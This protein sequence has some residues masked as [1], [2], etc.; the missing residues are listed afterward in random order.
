[1]SGLNW[2]GGML[3]KIWFWFLVLLTLNQ[4]AL[5][6]GLYVWVVRPAAS[7]FTNVSM[8]LVDTTA[9]QRQGGGSV[10]G[11]VQDHWVSQDHVMVV[12]GHPSDM[13]PVPPFPGLRLIEKIVHA[14]WGD[15]VQVG[16]SRDPERIL[17][18]QYQIGDPFSV[19]IPM[20]QRMMGLVFLLAAGL[21]IL[22]LSG[23]AAWIVAR[24]LTRP[25]ADLAYMA[26]RLG[27]GEAIGEIHLSPGGPTEIKHL[28]QTLNQMHEE[29]NQMLA[30]RERFLAGITHDLRTPLSRMRVALELSDSRDSELTEG[31]RD[32]IEE[33]RAILEQFM[34]LSR[35][36]MEKSE[37]SEL[38]DVNAVI[39]AVGEKYH[40]A[41]EAIVL[42]LAGV[43]E[44]RYKPLALKRL[45]YNLVDN[46]LRYGNGDV[47]IETGTDDSDT[48]W[49]SVTNRGGVSGSHDSA[50]VRALCWASNGQQSGLGLAIVRRLAKVHDARVSVQTLETGQRKVEI[51]FGQGL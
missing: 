21:L 44:A 10:L 2:R 36:D 43:P 13:G 38:G 23:V 16:F 41:G 9:Q 29:I 30:E 33:M 5:L 19:G 40:R 42:Q 47:V 26:R 25:L 18:F 51:R 17:W 34:E 32:D 24:R 50:L 45:L 6:V 27:R 35:L 28:A 46:A 11:L 22:F 14:T 7:S 15:K 31:L 4:I 39:R 49:L 48:A 8:A 1:M 12:A 37:P 3:R 20:N